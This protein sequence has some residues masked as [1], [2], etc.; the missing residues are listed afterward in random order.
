V[1]TLRVVADLSRLELFSGRNESELEPLASMLSP[2]GAPA[3]AVVARQGEAAQSFL[4][5]VMARPLSSV[6]MARA[7]AAWA[8]WC[9]APSS[10]S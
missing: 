3:G 8:P 2:V 10:A 7:S 5:V 4:L 1:D 6:T 9:R